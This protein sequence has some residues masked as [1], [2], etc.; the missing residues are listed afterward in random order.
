[1]KKIIQTSQ[2]PAAIGP[3][4][5][6]VEANGFVFFSGQIAIDPTTSEVVKGDIAV[7]TKRVMENINALLV[8]TGLG[9]NNVVKTTIFL[10]SMSDFSTVNEIYGTYFPGQPPA[11]STVAVSDLPKGVIVE[12][13]AIAVRA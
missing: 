11:R 7:Q 13:E 1:M 4:S 3:Y 10:T 5:Q 8:S 9:F 2:A 6:G 12:I